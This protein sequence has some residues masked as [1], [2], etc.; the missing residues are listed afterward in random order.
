[1]SRHT[2]QRGVTTQIHRNGYGGQIKCVIMVVDG[3]VALVSKIAL[4]CGSF[5]EADDFSI[6][7]IRHLGKTQAF[8]EVRK[9]FAMIRYLATVPKIAGTIRRM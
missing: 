9:L 8:R 3:I 7:A 5:R 1:M 4:V 2:A 6:F